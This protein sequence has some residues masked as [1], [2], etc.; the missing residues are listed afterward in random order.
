[1]LWRLNFSP[2]CCGHCVLWRCCAY[3]L[4]WHWLWPDTIQ[5][6]QT[7]ELLEPDKN[8][9]KVQPFHLTGDQTKMM[10]KHRLDESAVTKVPNWHFGSAGG[11]EGA[12]S[13]PDSGWYRLHCTTQ[14]LG[15]VPVNCSTK[16]LTRGHLT[17][18]SSWMMKGPE[19]FK[20]QLILLQLKKKNF[21]KDSACC[22]ETS[23][24]WW[25]YSSGRQ[26]GPLCIIPCCLRIY[27]EIIPFVYRSLWK[28]LWKE[29]TDFFFSYFFLRK[30]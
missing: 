10:H 26:S 18:K 27:K 22:S 24:L 6:H 11:T 4:Q 7:T 30:C 23:N 8:T 17:K 15:L 2:L 20:T 21:S 19:F 16:L 25:L 3:R 14:E 12:S 9:G 5:T 1:M 28:R 29:K 13:S